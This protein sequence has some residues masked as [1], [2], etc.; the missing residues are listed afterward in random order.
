MYGK[1][2]QKNF[3]WPIEPIF[4]A[5]LPLSSRANFTPKIRQIPLKQFFSH[6]NSL[7]LEGMYG[8]KVQKIFLGPIEPIFGAMLALPEKM[9]LAKFGGQPLNPLGEIAGSSLQT[10]GAVWPN[11]SQRISQRGKLQL[12]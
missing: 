1:K 6:T 4:G 12:H 10:T 7:K 3:F 2:N 9:G 8:K 11:F 5:M